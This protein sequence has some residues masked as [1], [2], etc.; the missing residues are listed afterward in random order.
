MTHTSLWGFVRL[1]VRALSLLQFSLFAFWLFPL[2]HILI[3]FYF[4]RKILNKFD[5]E[6]LNSQRCILLVG[7]KLT[8]FPLGRVEVV[9]LKT[10]TSHAYSVKTLCSLRTASSY[11]LIQV[12]E[13]IFSKALNS[14]AI[15]S[16]FFS[17][18][19]ILKRTVRYILS[20]FVMF[21]TGL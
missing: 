3:V 18:M 13:Y 14:S 9:G 1:S 20:V 11:T 2:S 4:P 8:P 6:R 16:R 5:M 12:S 10:M 19:N 7:H 15:M 21:S 17:S